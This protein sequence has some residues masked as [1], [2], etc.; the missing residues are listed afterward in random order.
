MCFSNSFLMSPTAPIT[1]GIVSV[2]MPHILVVSISRSL[3]F[4]SDL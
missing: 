1:T 3:N 2:F 4:E